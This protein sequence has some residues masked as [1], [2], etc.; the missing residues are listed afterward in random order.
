MTS[1]DIKRVEIHLVAND[2]RIFYGVADNNIVTNMIY[3]FVKF[4]ELDKDRFREADVKEF[5]K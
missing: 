3:K 1:E 2:G 4:I 5:I